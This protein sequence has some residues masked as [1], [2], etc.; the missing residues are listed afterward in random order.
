MEKQIASRPPF[1][2]EHVG[3]LLR[4]R[5]LTGAFHAFAGG[6]MSAEKFHEIQDQAIVEVVRM[7]EKVGLEAVTDGEFRRGSYWGHFVEK[8]EGLAVAPALF[9]FTDAE[10]GS[11]AFTA[12]HVEG[13]VRRTQGISTDEFA[14]LRGATERVP[15]I[16]MP[17]PPTMHFYRG[18]E[19]IAPGAY[20][21]LG[22]FFD[23]LAR[24]Y[25][26]EI[27]ALWEL[28]ARYIQMD[29]VPLAMLCDPRAREAVAAR[30]EKPEAL[31]I[32]YVDAINGALAQ[33]PEG[34]VAGLH[35]CRG[36]F[37]GKY[38]SEG[39]YD[40]VAERLFNDI[41]VDAFFLEYD[42]PRAGDF[43]PLRF[44]PKDK[45]VVL[46]LVSSKTP[47]LEP[48]DQLQRRVEE[49]AGYVA[50]ER[51]AISPQCGFASTVAGNPVTYDDEVRKLT[52]VVE[53]AARIWG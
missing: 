7:Q 5:K 20:D 45:W 38:L 22:A 30:G 51:L 25:R 14:F 24:V 52:L 31:A 1:H 53:T 2:A 12:P 10:G 3:S 44:V 47:A 36:N 37:K 42:T 21:G 39:G 8:V 11:Q 28:G 4:P 50:S 29:E 15:K 33:R 6:E 13:K 17:S 43:A 9:S 41:A 40:E 49:A 18:P 35:L 16:T 34:M 27:A 23:D 26:E 19:G 46:G 48:I 32:A